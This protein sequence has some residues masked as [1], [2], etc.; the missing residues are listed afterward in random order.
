LNQTCPG[1][2]QAPPGANLSKNS[3]DHTP[4][5]GRRHDPPFRRGQPIRR[6]G[7]PKPLPCK[8]F[9]PRSVGRVPATM[10]RSGRRSATVRVGRSVL[11]VRT[12]QGSFRLLDGS[13]TGRGLAC[14][15]KPSLLA[16]LRAGPL[17]TLTMN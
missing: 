3:W 13:A 10:P 8:G 1:V 7:S 17:D 14:R 2:R 12:V 6:S 16:H 15:T 11:S 5:G 4:S 9:P